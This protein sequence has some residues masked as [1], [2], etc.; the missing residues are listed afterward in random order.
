MVAA[1]AIGVKLRG[2]A[3]GGPYARCWH[4]GRTARSAWSA[5][6]SGALDAG[7]WPALRIKYCESGGLP[8]PKG[9]PDSRSIYESAQRLGLRRQSAT[10]TALSQSQRASVGTTP[11]LPKAVSRCA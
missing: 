11:T 4:C 2:A 7:V 1:Q 8:P 6:Y 3:G 5:P 10:A 9:L